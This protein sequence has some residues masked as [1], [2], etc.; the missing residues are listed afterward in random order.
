MLYNPKKKFHVIKYNTGDFM[1]R[2]KS[3]PKITVLKFN[4]RRGSCRLNVGL[5]SANNSLD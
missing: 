3:E 4:W 1:I 5:L 2:T